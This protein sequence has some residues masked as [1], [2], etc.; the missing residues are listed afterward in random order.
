MRLNWK[1]FWTL[2]ND[3]PTCRAPKNAMAKPYFNVS[4]IGINTMSLTSCGELDGNNHFELVRRVPVN[5]EPT[6][7]SKYT[8][9]IPAAF[10]SRLTRIEL[11]AL[12]HLGSLDVHFFTNFRPILPTSSVGPVSCHL[13]PSKK[14]Q[15]MAPTKVKAAPSA[16]RTR[17]SGIHNHLGPSSITCATPDYQDR[18]SPQAYPRHPSLST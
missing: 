9:R 1:L 7:S 5:L 10:N 16:S 3:G 4:V 6:Y 18:G 14:Q 15:Y 13:P 2:K 11:S 12:R 17:K 8:T